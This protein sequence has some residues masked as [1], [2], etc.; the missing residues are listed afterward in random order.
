MPY[1]NLVS[2]TNVQP[3]VPEDVVDSVIQGA[4]TQSA[5]LSLFPRV[6][7]STNQQR[8]PVLSVLPTAYFVNGDTGLKQTTE[9]AWTNQY[10]NVEEIAAIVP[11]PE[12]VLDDSGFDLWGE[13]QPRLEEAIGRILDAA[14]FFQVNKPAS[15]PTGIV[16]GAVAAGNAYARG[17]A[18]P[19]QGGIAEDFNQVYGLVEADGFDVNGVVT[20]RTYRSRLRGARDTTGQKLLDLGP[21]GENMIDGARLIYAMPGLWPTGFSAAEAIVGDFSQVMLGVRKDFTYKLLT[22]AVITDN[23]GAVIYNLPQQDMVALRVVA[24]FAYGVANPTNFDQPTAA[25]RWPFGVLR[26]PAS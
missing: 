24:R 19:A 16:A 14:I 9:Q 15:W 26:S 8:I 11:V 18:T 4:I 23:T 25:A 13:V 3:L 6:N 17:T 5:A 12:A 21:N 20:R 7:I 22:E 10:L 1:N 2:R